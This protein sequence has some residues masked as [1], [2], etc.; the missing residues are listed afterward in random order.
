MKIPRI[1]YTSG[2]PA[3]VGLDLALTLAAHNFAAQIVVLA[4]PKH[5]S[6]RIQERSSL[7]NKTPENNTLENKAIEIITIDDSFFSQAVFSNSNANTLYVYPIEDTLC[8]N[9]IAG[10]A[11]KN[12]SPYILAMLD[13]A[14]NLCATGNADAMVTGPINKALINDYGINFSGHTEYLAEATNT[15]KTVMMLSND[16]VSV[17]LATTHIPLKAVAEAITEANLRETLTIMHDY[18]LQFN[19]KPAHI[20]VLG[21]NPH[22]GE[23]GHIGT[24]EKDFITN[25]LKALN[26][27]GMNLHGPLSAD[28]AF[29]QPLLTN[30]DM[31]LAMYHDQ[32]LPIVKYTGFGNTVNITLGLPITR[33][34]VDHGTAYALAAGDGIDSGSLDK[35]IAVAIGI[36]QNKHN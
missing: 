22:A 31:Y 15:K 32:G 1:L 10:H 8:H 21:L 23:D 11:E 34:S 28:T 14:I 25:T 33:T 12:T 2:D 36:T 16:T 6:Q 9:V 7:G 19:T 13:K 20:S 30:T 24:E 4:D 5:L 29:C 27:E 26:H 18:W 35:A 17:C 3:G